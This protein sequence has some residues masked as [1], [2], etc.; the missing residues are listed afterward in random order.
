MTTR[1]AAIYTRISRDR[2]AEG[3]RGLGVARQEKEIR[4]A[5]DRAGY[6]GPVVVYSDN[7]VSAYSGK[8]RPGYDAM[9][10]AMTAGMVGSLWAWHTDRLHRS[11]SELETFIPAVN[12]AAVEIQTVKSGVLDLSSAHGRM[13]ARI[14]GAVDV[15]ESEHKGERIVAKHREL[16]NAGK[17]HGGQR[18]FGYE[19]KMATPRESEAVVVREVANRI[20]AG[21]SLRSITKDINARGVVTVSGKP[22]KPENLRAMVLGAHHAGLRTYRGTVVG[23]AEWAAILPRPTWEAVQAVLTA[24]ERRVG[25]SPHRKYAL[26]GV[27]RC[28][29]CGGVI[30]GRMAGKGKY[31]QPAYMCETTGHVHRAVVHVDEWISEAVGRWLTNADSDGT[32]FSPDEGHEAEGLTVESDTLRERRAAIATEYGLGTLD[33]AGYDGAVAA[34]DNRLREITDRLGDIARTPAVF[35]DLVGKPNAGQL[36]RAL[37]VDRQREVLAA[38]PGTVTL[39]PGRRGGKGSGAE[40]FDPST[41]KIVWD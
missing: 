7:D 37:P 27:G 38:M 11:N 8:P 5:M 4:E 14:V 18:R 33:R 19:P 21:E 9:V 22:W 10:E 16:A 17:F 23:D 36:Y 24:P 26:T 34:I 12:E 13:I 6:S 15:A 28:G 1:H 25:S 29:V 39:Y 31:R 30:R 41:V 32:F 3:G 40:R 20:I 35:A 2:S